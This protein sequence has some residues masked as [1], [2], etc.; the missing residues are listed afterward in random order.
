MVSTKNEKTQFDATG[1]LLRDA[2]GGIELSDAEFEMA[3]R[4][5]TPPEAMK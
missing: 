4:I 3:L 2:I 5:M 1:D